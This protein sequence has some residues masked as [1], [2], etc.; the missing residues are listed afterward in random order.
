MTAQK[1]FRGSENIISG[2]R[3]GIIGKF[4]NCKLLIT[5]ILQREAILCLWPP[6]M[7]RSE[8]THEKLRQ[9]QV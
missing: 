2:E 6:S 8:K 3:G 5:K 4:L 7:D 9:R 1:A